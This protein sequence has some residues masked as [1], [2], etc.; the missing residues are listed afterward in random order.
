MCVYPFSPEGG[1]TLIEEHWA[2]ELCG[3][4]RAE[5][6]HITLFDTGNA[7]IHSHLN[8]SIVLYLYHIKNGGS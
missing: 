1:L 7:M 8:I 6:I 4:T 5:T 2:F 3:G